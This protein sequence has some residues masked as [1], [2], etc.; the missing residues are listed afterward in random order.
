MANLSLPVSTSMATYGCTGW[1]SALYTAGAGFMLMTVPTDIEVD[2][3][4]S[5]TT[6]QITVAAKTWQTGL[7]IR[8]VDVGATGPS[9][10][11]L[12]TGTDYFL[13]RINATTFQLASSYANAQ[14]PTPIAL[15]NISSGA[16]GITVQAPSESWSIAELTDNE[17]SHPLYTARPLFPAPGSLPAPVVAG[18][19]VSIDVLIAT[20]NNTDAATYTYNAIALLLAPG[21]VGNTSGVT[22]VNAGRLENPPGTP[23]SISIAQYDTSDIKYQIGIATA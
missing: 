13:I 21:A 22:V 23:V 3:T 14:T 5:S 19:N 8:I 17:I 4:A 9:I 2:F 20:V 7:R 15:P 12:A 16:Y 18:S 6:N 10:S 1:A 11:P